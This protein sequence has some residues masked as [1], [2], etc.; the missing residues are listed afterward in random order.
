MELWSGVKISKHGNE[1]KDFDEFFDCWVEQQKI[2]GTKCPYLNIEM[3][4]IKGKSKCYMK[5]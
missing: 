1:F 4:K 3:T 2:Y 5:L